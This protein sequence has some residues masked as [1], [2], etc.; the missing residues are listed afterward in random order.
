M[1]FDP[2]C[3]WRSWPISLGWAWLASPSPPRSCHCSLRLKLGPR[4]PP[5]P[6]VVVATARTAVGSVAPSTRRA[7]KRLVQCHS[8]ASG[9]ARLVPVPQRTRPLLHHQLPPLLLRLLLL[10]RRR[11]V[12]AGAPGAHVVLRV[13]VLPLPTIAAL[14]QQRALSS[15]RGIC[16]ASLHHPHVRL[17]TPLRHAS[18]LAC[19]VRHLR[20]TLAQPFPQSFTPNPKPD[21]ALPVTTVPRVVLVW[22]SRRHHPHTHA[23]TNVAWSRARLL[24]PMPRTRRV[25]WLRGRCP[26]C[27]PSAWAAP[28]HW[29][30]VPCRRHGTSLATA[31]CSPPRRVHPRWCA[32]TLSPSAKARILTGRTATW[33]SSTATVLCLGCLMAMAGAALD[34]KR[35]SSALSSCAASSPPPPP[36]HPSWRMSWGVHHPPPLMAMETGTQVRPPRRHRH[37]LQ[38]Q[39]RRHQ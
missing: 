29:P 21:P 7:C 9:A 39:Q 20:P 30:H 37:L 10:R 6:S 23:H 18:Q 31:C 38:R 1:S 14:P 28:R 3:L 12:A 19:L 22:T 24:L 2:F 4:R 8:P 25:V 36:P 16:P 15:P 17:H 32:A 13:V 35:Q 34:T 33:C 5:P 26:S 27:P 11:L